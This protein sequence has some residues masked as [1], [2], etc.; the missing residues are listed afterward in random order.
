MSAASPI[1]RGTLSLRLWLARAALIWERA[2]PAA[3]PLIAA[4]AVWLI[5]AL[6]DLL[7]LLPGVL[8]LAVLVVL[9]A[10]V[11]AAGI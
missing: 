1:E 6:F 4:L 5:L 9:L 3:W 7:P 8:H 2:W 11:V 10:A